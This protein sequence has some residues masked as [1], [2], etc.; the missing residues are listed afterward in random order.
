MNNSANTSIE[1]IISPETLN[2]N[3]GNITSLKGYTYDKGLLF[4][5][6]NLHKKISLLER[7]YLQ[8]YMAGANNVKT[9]LSEK[10]M[11]ILGDNAL[12]SEKIEKLNDK[13]DLKL[14]KTDGV[15]ISD[16]IDKLSD[17]FDVKLDK[18]DNKMEKISENIATINSNFA[19]IAAVNSQKSKDKKDSKDR[20]WVIVSMVA[21]TLV[22]FLIDKFVH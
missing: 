16:K 8:G 19:V 14:D 15:L 3:N 9:S 21:N 12:I 10:E 18:F 20:F 2:T 1:S 7:T 5:E 4:G 13:L 17:K 11:F 22:V 6:D